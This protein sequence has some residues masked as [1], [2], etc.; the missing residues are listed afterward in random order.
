MFSDA[1]KVGNL[2]GH[3][4]ETY[5]DRVDQCPTDE[6]ACSSTVK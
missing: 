4:C 6:T 3:G 1:D 2:S 5:A